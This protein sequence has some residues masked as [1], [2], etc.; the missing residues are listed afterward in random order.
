MKEKETK[1][2]WYYPQIDKIIK[3]NG[4]SKG[5]CPFC[6]EEYNILPITSSLI[7]DPHIDQCINKFTVFRYGEK[8]Y[9]IPFAVV[10]RLGNDRYSV[11]YNFSQKLY[12]AVDT[13]KN[14]KG[15]ILETIYNE[16]D[17]IIDIDQLETYLLFR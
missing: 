11:L 8:E 2:I 1:I 16:S 7:E 14:N 6:K 13:I 4:T 3:A 12:R 9:V 17:I 10:Y 5:T 15:I